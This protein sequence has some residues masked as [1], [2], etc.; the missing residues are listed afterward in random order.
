ME[1]LLEAGLDVADYGRRE[2]QMHPK[3]LLDSDYGEA[4]VVFEY[5]EHAGGCRIHV[6]E[7]WIYNADEEGSASTETSTSKEPSPMPCN[8]DFDDA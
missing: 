6:T 7:L 5:G 8:W 3:G 1:V 2:K 4:R